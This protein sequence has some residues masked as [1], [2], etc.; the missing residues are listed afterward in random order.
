MLGEVSVLPESAVN[1]SLNRP[2]V[3]AKITPFEFGIRGSALKILSILRAKR[4]SHWGNGHSATITYNKLCSLSNLARGTVSR[5]LKILEKTGYIRKSKG[6]IGEANRY[7]LLD[8]IARSAPAESADHQA[9]NERHQ[10]VTEALFN[11][12]S[13]FHDDHRRRRWAKK[14]NNQDHHHE[15]HGAN[16]YDQDDQVSRQTQ[17][18]EKAF[19]RGLHSVTS[20]TDGNRATSQENAQRQINELHRELAGL[21]ADVGLLLSGNNH[22]VTSQQESPDQNLLLSL[23]I[24]LVQMLLV[25]VQ[26]PPSLS[27][28]GGSSSVARIL[29]T[30]PS[31]EVNDATSSN[32]STANET[33]NPKTSLINELITKLSGIVDQLSSPKTRLNKHDHQND[34]QLSATTAPMLETKQNADWNIFKSIKLLMRQPDSC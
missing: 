17:R 32:S 25:Q 33:I 3:F 34:R 21:R 31:G 10:A 26:S 8:A 13:E 28:V 11:D 15:D 27:L 29:D 23:L 16:Y 24:G 4:Y 20:T 9:K 7:E 12:A 6:R 1:A 2:Q 22:N 5:G 30:N 19:S 18:P 14:F